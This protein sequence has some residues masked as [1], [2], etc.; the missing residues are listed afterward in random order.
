MR[1]TTTTLIGGTTSVEEQLKEAS[2]EAKKKEEIYIRSTQNLTA[3]LAEPW[4]DRRRKKIE[5]RLERPFPVEFDW[6]ARRGATNSQGIKIG[7]EGLETP[8]WAQVTLRHELDHAKLL[9]AGE[10]LSVGGYEAYYV[11]RGS[12]GASQGTFDYQLEELIVRLRDYEHMHHPHERKPKFDVHAEALPRIKAAYSDL[13]NA[14]DID[15][16]DP[17]DVKDIL[18]K[19]GKIAEALSVPLE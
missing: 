6:N 4:A 7:P 18:D 10:T 15:E 5:Q 19:L 3:V 14:S 9:V 12:T 11:E 8:G 16:L 1:L 2:S 13:K 17:T